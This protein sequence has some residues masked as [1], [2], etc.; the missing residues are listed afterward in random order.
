MLF[1]DWNL[2][3][4]AVIATI[5]G[6]GGN[7]SQLV[8]RGSRFF[9]FGNEIYFASNSSFGVELFKLD[10]IAPGGAVLISDAAPGLSSSN[11]LAIF[12]FNSTLFYYISA[13]N[14]TAKLFRCCPT[15]EV[16][17][18]GPL[19]SPVLASAQLGR[20]GNYLY[21]SIIGGDIISLTLLAGTFDTVTGAVDTNVWLP[22]QN[23][24][25]RPVGAA[26]GRTSKCVQ[27]FA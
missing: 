27:P 5:P 21:F 3:R 15:T 25:S 4:E 12:Q 11:P 17:D 14:S 13:Q 20:F 6:V 9:K 19:A 1:A 26:V 8:T 16:A 18:L 7:S 23:G 2:L 22:P 10:A 24:L